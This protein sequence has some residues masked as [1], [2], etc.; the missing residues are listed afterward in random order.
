MKFFLLFSDFCCLKLKPYMQNFWRQFVM[1]EEI[2]IVTQRDI[3]STL[4]QLWLRPVNMFLLWGIYVV[5]FHLSSNF[6]R[7]TQGAGLQEH[8]MTDSQFAL[9]CTCAYQEVRNN[10]FSK[11]LACFVF[12]CHPV[13]D[14]PFCL[15]VNDLCMNAALA[16]IPSQ[17]VIKSFDQLCIFIWISI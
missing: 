9:H 7:H 2:T 17:N 15:I 4:N 14:L 13:W 8:C 10:C 12:L 16:L 3:L 6:W 5:V 1:M 11:N